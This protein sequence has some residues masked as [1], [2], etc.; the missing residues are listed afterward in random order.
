VRAWRKSVD[1]PGSDPGGLGPVRVRLSPPAPRASAVTGNRAGSYPAD[2]SSNLRGRTRD[3]EVAPFGSGANGSTPG[4]EPGDGGSCP[5]S[6]AL[7]RRLR[8]PMTGCG[9]DGSARR[10]GRRGRRFE[11]GQ[12]DEAT[13][14]W[15]VSSVGRATDCRSGGRGFESRTRRKRPLW[16]KQDRRPPSHPGGVRDNTGACE[17]PVVSSSLAP[18]TGSRLAV[19]QRIQSAALRRQVSSVRIGPARLRLRPTRAR[20]TARRVH[21]RSDAQHLPPSDSGSPPDSQ[22]GSRGSAPRG[23]TKMRGSSVVERPVVARRRR[24]FDA[25]PRSTLGAE[26]LKDA[27]VASTH[28][29]P[30]RYRPA[31]PSP[32]RRPG[33]AG[34]EPDGTAPP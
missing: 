32:G 21:S 14:A 2:R 8:E 10:S 6:R 22:S 31:L 16:C 1:A 4:S 18:G 12:P 24:G 30:G 15:R 9:A 23:G 25:L 13:A 20:C 5:P 17:A 19:A 29:E 28:E 3:S 11:P 34:P 26:V 7:F 27:R 33:R